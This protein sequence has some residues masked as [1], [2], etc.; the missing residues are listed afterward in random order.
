MSLYCCI[1]L[2]SCTAAR[3]FNKLTYLPTY[4]YNTMPRPLE[5]VERAA[6]FGSTACKRAITI[7]DNA[8]CIIQPVYCTHAVNA[9]QQMRDEL[10]TKRAIHKKNYTVNTIPNYKRPDHVSGEKPAPRSNLF[11]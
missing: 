9:P 10:C 3:V 6:I 7:L 8:Q 11:L 4:F 2:F 1:D 5:P